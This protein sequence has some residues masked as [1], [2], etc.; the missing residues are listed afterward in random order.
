MNKTVQPDCDWESLVAQ[1]GCRDEAV[2][3][4]AIDRLVEF[5][6]ADTLPIFLEL[7]GDSSWRLRK[8]AVELLLS[9]SAREEVVDG[10]IPL[11][12]DSRNSLRRNAAVDALAQCGE[13]AIP[14]LIQVVQ[15]EDSEVRKLVIDIFGRLGSKQ[16]IEHLSVFLR[17]QDV[18]VQAAAADALG[19]IGGKDVAPSLVDVIRDSSSNRFVRFS[20]LCALERL[21]VKLSRDEVGDVFSDD[22]LRPAAFQVLDC[23]ND[24]RT[25]EMLLESLVSKSR[26]SRESAINALL[27]LHRKCDATFTKKL[28]RKVR[29]S[30]QGA[31]DVVNDALERLKSADIQTRMTLV[32]FLGLLGTPE[33]VIPI[34]WAAD[35]P[36]MSEIVVQTLIA[37]GA[38]A[39]R[40]IITTWDRLSRESQLLG[41]EVLGG[42]RGELGFEHLTKLLQG[43]VIDLRAEALRAV[44]RYGGARVLEAIEARFDALLSETE[45]AREIELEAVNDAVRHFAN[46]SRES[47]ALL[48]QLMRGL[49]SRSKGASDDVRLAIASLLAELAR[50][51]EEDVIS[52][53]AKDPCAGVRRE[54]VRGFAR[55]GVGREQ[56]RLM[57]SDESAIVRAA[58][59]DALAIIGHCSELGDLQHLTHDHD[60]SVRAS[61]IRALGAI[62]RTQTV[63]K[64]ERSQVFLRFEEILNDDGIVVMA[65]LEALSLLGGEQSVRLALEILDSDDVDLIQEAIRCIVEHGTRNDVERILPFVTHSEWLLRAAAI[66]AVGERSLGAGRSQIDAMLET[67]SDPYVVEVARRTL[68]ALEIHHNEET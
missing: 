11:L 12:L 58:A 56:V 41:C 43:D 10:L 6:L 34:L 45:L 31:P 3:R 59:A 21:D 67:E 46:S 38:I 7:V 37:I 44:G 63:S 28:R 49:H 51:S 5:P 33:V 1:I 25:I 19:M 9:S 68:A 8:R 24:D 64:A 53:L 36:T 35:D 47:A 29:I 39:E 27:R 22:L 32:P 26:S 65:V 23:L 40:V 20:A 60:P 42:I 16:T 66:Q 18:N 4:H 15:H 17:D 14:R 13:E 2:R 62:A 54:S 61:S 52:Q 55:L 48:D 30:I 57:L 50:S